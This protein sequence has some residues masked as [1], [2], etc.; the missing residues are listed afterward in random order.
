MAK[1]KNN[2]P[3]RIIYGKQLIFN[4]GAQIYLP[5]NSDLIGGAYIIKKGNSDPYASNTSA[6]V[7]NSNYD[8]TRTF[9]YCGLNKICQNGQC[10][11]YT[12]SF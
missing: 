4:Q 10:V 3:I 7:C 8:S 6:S 11:D 12:P 5:T 1:K 2:K 9:K